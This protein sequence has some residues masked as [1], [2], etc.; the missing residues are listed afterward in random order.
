MFRG[1]IV[2]LTCCKKHLIRLHHAAVKSVH[3]Y[4]YFC[5]W[6]YAKSSLDFAVRATDTEARMQNICAAGLITDSYRS[7]SIVTSWIEDVENS[8]N[9]A[10]NDWGDEPLESVKAIALAA[11]LHCHSASGKFEVIE[12]ELGLNLNILAKLD[13]TEWDFA[14]NRTTA[15]LTRHCS[16]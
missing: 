6:T 1:F 3:V 4:T 15:A 12:T 10:R 8:W 16:K 7:Y 14:N 9:C 2:F 13:M 11:L 5:A